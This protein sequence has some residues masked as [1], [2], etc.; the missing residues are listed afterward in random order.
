MET[1]RIKLTNDPMRMLRHHEIVRGWLASGVDPDRDAVPVLR[2]VAGRTGYE[3][4]RNLSYFTAMIAEARGRTSQVAPAPKGYQVPAYAR[5]FMP[6]PEPGAGDDDHD[7][8]AL[9]GFG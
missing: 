1:E 7:D 9:R 3:P 2:L 8:P 6:K 4:P 5:R